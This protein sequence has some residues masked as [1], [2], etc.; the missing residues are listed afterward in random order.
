MN[1]SHK[2]ED[3]L[4][5]ALARLSSYLEAQGLRTTRQRAAI[6]AIVLQL[7]RH[8]HVDEIYQAVR[9][10]SPRIGYATVYRT[11][12]LLKE[13]NLVAERHFDDG[14][15]RYE[16]KLKDEHHDHLICTVCNKIIEFENNEIERLQDLVAD[17]HGFVVDWHKHEIYGRCRAC[18]AS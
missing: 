9:T 18:I 16:P 13:A 3:V 8:A 2:S 11:L 17:S 15:T 12:K 6:A 7:D 1:S 4:E 5:D 10:K 14:L